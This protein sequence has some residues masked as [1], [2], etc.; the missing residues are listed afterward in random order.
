MVRDDCCSSGWFGSVDVA[1][2][3]T[4]GA[5]Q[6]SSLIDAIDVSGKSDPPD[7]AIC[8]PP[9]G[10]I[11]ALA[12]DLARPSVIDGDPHR[13]HFSTRQSGFLN[14]THTRSYIAPVRRSLPRIEIRRWGIY[15]RPPP[16][17]RQDNSPRVAYIKLCLT[18]PR[19]LATTR[20][21]PAALLWYVPLP[22]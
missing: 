5:R 13:P 21:I 20:A 15:R 14:P 22:P 1:N 7:T 17:P 3:T 11:L 18:V 19:R 4:S 9:V 2:A 16:Y 10:Y 6:P 12:C 8:T